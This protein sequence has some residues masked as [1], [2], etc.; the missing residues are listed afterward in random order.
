MARRIWALAVVLAAALA[1]PAAG[2]HRNDEEVRRAYAQYLRALVGSGRMAT[3]ADQRELAA[4]MLETLGLDRLSGAQILHLAPAVKIAARAGDVRARL[5]QLAKDQGADGALAALALYY[6]FQRTPQEAAEALSAALQHPGI[7]EAIAGAW[8]RE[9]LMVLH[10]H[11]SS[12]PALPPGAEEVAAVFD[13]G[14]GLSAI[15]AMDVFLMA[16]D[17]AGY[18]RAE[19]ESLRSAMIRAVKRWRRDLDNPEKLVAHGESMGNPRALLKKNDD[20][21]RSI[22]IAA[23]GQL[24]QLA[25]RLDS[26]GGGRIGR[27]AP[28]LRLEWVVGREGASEITDLKGRVVVLVSWYRWEAENSGAAL[29]NLLAE[30]YAGRPVE[31]VATTSYLPG[32]LVAGG[33]V[34]DQGGTHEEQRRAIRAAAEREGLKVPVAAVEMMRIGNAYGTN[35][36]EAAVVDAAGIVRGVGMSADSDEEKQRLFELIDLLLSEMDA[37]PEPAA[38]PK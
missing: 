36:G 5:E 32:Q 25:R 34:I 35:I 3:A 9:V 20:V 8:A 12:H 27:P 13:R 1:A 21:L 37:K 17:Q 29:C 4:S 2:Q 38:E 23:A 28:D 18:E 24:D 6:F 31:V 33:A 26:L 14:L 19:L 10:G 16:V 11:V 7:E 22:R 15:G 30:R